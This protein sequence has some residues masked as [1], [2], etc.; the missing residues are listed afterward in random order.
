MSDARI[1]TILM[2][3]ISLNNIY[4]TGKGGKR[5]LRKDVKQLKKMIQDAL[6]A[7]DMQ[8][9]KKPLVSPFYEVVL[10]VWMPHDRF[11]FKN[12]K[13]RKLDVSNMIKVIEDALFEYI[14]QGNDSQVLTVSVNKRIH[15]KDES[16]VQIILRPVMDECHPI[17]TGAELVYP[18][19]GDDAVTR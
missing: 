4:P 1:Y 10:I 8:Q 7:L 15:P 17:W 14:K 18:E 11:F 13:V 6:W 5:Y 12:G 2:Q 3:P 16:L 19:R 9:K